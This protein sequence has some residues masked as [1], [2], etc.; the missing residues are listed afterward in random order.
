MA[1]E[2]DQIVMDDD[3]EGVD[4]F[5]YLGSMLQTEDGTSIAEVLSKLS[6]QLENQNKILIK[7]LSALTAAKSG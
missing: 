7:I 2:E 4:P 6:T 1:E 5:E 3:E